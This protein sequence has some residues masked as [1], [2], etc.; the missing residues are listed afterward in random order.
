MR[1]LFL[2]ILLAACSGS[3]GQSEVEKPD[4]NNQKDATDAPPQE[5]EATPEEKFQGQQAATCKAMCERITDCAVEDAKA[6]M[7]PEELA[8]L[9]LENTVPK[10]VEECT[11]EYVSKD[12]SPRQVKIIRDCLAQETDCKAYLDCLSLAAKK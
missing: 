3:S 11:N 7:S 12:L 5:P 10:A 6:N 1:I 4:P 2:G 9:D 8:K